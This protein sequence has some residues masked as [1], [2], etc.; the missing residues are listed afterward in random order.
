MYT[1]LSRKNP[2]KP[3]HSRDDDNTN[4]KHKWLQK[5]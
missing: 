2:I 5:V 4:D 1:Q 3:E